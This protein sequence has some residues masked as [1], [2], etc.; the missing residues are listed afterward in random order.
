MQDL[1]STNGNP[2]S[3]QFLSQ[4]ALNRAV[5]E[6]SDVLR[7]SNCSGAMQYI[8]ELTWILFLRFLDEQEGQEAEAARTEGRTF[9][10][11]VA[12]P[13]RWRD[14]AA[15]LSAR[16]LF[17]RPNMDM[18]R[19]WKRLEI[20]KRGEQSLLKFVNDELFPYLKTLAAS[21]NAM[22]KQKVITEIA[23]NIDRTRID[24]DRNFLDV[25]DLVDAISISQIDQTHIFALS[26]LYEGLLLRMGQKSNDGGQ[27]FT[28][29]EVVRCIVK[30][31]SP[32]RG[33]TVYDP[34]CGTGGFLVQAHQQSCTSKTVEI[35]AT[36]RHSSLSLFGREKENLVYP[37]A[38]ANLVIHGIDEPHLWH[39]NTLTSQEI[40]GRLFREAPRQFDVVL[41]NPPFGGKESSE[42]Q[43]QFRYKSSSTQLLFLQHVIDSLKEGGRCGIVVDEGLLFRTND[44]AF[45]QTK[46][47]LLN[48]CDVWCIV[49]LPLGA[50]VNAGASIKTNILFFTKGRPTERIWYYDLSDLKVTKSNPLGEQHFEEFFR[51]LASRGDSAQSWSITRQ[52]IETSG[53]DLKA[54]NP[55]FRWKKDQRAK[56][57]LLSLLEEGNKEIG[58]KIRKLRHLQYGSEEPK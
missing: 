19:G 21:D 51:L 48:T 37:L 1:V 17:Q 41:T 43:V 23:V 56:E 36:D 26:Q 24:T 47:W 44:T 42:A 14:W 54:V 49:S 32:G 2:G 3:K 33:E 50:F 58:E 7:R 27:F 5:K 15:P 57:E 13:Y 4:Q 6:I 46:R 52:Q 10:P 53:Y 18:D 20:K 31:V 29:R 34:C 16:S 11:S 35:D 38:L 55:H 40:S 12:S 9:V 8:P 39:G 25:L 28:P 22:P 30:V 45:A